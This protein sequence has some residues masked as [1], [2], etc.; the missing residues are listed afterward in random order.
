[1][2][3]IKSFDSFFITSK[4][5]DEIKFKRYLIQKAKLSTSSTRPSTQHRTQIRNPP[6]DQR[7]T[8]QRNPISMLLVE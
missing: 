1:L 5:I 3:L 4:F 7:T 2:S 6:Q 8:T